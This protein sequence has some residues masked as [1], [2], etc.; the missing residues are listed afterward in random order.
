[1]RFALWGLAIAGGLYCLHR[2]A[3]WAEKRGWIYYR[4]HPASSGVLGNAFL[5]V[6]TLLEPGKRHVL[7]ERTRAGGETRESG[8]PPN[9]GHGSTSG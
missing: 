8:D 4:K 3:S 7:E 2:L 6:Q 9:P 1:M 5:E